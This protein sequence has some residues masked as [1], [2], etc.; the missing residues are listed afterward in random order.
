MQPFTDKRRKM[1]TKKCDYSFF[2]RC[3]CSSTGHG[4]TETT[5]W[6]PFQVKILLVV[7]LVVI[8]FCV[9]SNFFVSDSE[10]KASRWAE[11]APLEAPER[12]RCKI[13]YR[14]RG[15]ESLPRGIVSATSDFERRSLWGVS[16][17]QEKAKKSLLAI[18]V[19]INQKENVD[20]IVKKFPP[21]NF[22][23]MLFHYDGVVDQWRDFPWSES[24]L[25]ISAINQTKWWF[26]KRFLHPDI[27]AEYSYIF[28]WD[29]DLDVDH[30]HPARYLFI[31]EE[32]GLEISQ[33]ALDPIKSAV[34]HRITVRSANSRVHRRAYKFHGSG[35]CYEN[36]TAPPCT[37]WV[38][39]MAPVF[40]RAAWRCAWHM[41]QNDLIHAWGLDMRLGYCAQGERS[42][43]V[44]V[45]DSEY[46]V[47][48][49]MRT[50]GHPRGNKAL[51]D[52][53]ASSTRSEV[54][55]QCLRELE[56]FRERWDK[57][58]M[59]DD[60]WTDPYPPATSGSKTS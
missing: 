38:E 54:R 1:T 33:P 16:R 5:N 32:E 37:G 29:E 20:N 18:A 36:S 19:G 43:N 42:T 41:I 12:S 3:T 47:H 30:F 34:H 48:L 57:A 44:G 23:I 15:T 22:T 6:R 14:A 24:T 53:P 55:K 7:P 27:V 56:I 35:R 59:D 21:T 10:E 28:L 39:M 40:S 52:S 17:D 26:A 51:D 49:G 46:L 58:V 9:G 4:L 2:G 31:V 45:V 11:I 60:C 13:Q 25:H 50:L 8:A